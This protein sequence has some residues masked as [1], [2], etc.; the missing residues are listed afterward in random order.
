MTV[1]PALFRLAL[2]FMIEPNDDIID[3]KIPF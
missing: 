2:G 3:T 1:S